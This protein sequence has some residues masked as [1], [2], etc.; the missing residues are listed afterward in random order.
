MTVA[1]VAFSTAL[2]IVGL[3]LLDLCLFH[4][5]GSGAIMGVAVLIIVFAG[6]LNIVVIYIL[7]N[8][9][10]SERNR[11][12]ATL[13][14]LGYYNG[15]VTGYIYREVYINSFIGILFGYPASLF[16][17]WL[18][19]N[20]MGIGSIGGVSWFMWLIAPVVVLLFTGLVALVLR[21]KIV[22]VHMNES[23]KAI[24]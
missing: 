10:I 20:T 5:F 7:T 2:V 16:L 4:Y 8:I 18:V 13:M 1:A 22:K 15:E 24:E 9:N 11:E 23:L 19:F 21:G 14:V 6:L 3:G 17:L 12:I